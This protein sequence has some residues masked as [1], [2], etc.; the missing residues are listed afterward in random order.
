MC[1]NVQPLHEGW[2]CKTAPTLWIEPSI[3]PLFNEPLAITIAEYLPSLLVSVE[4][5]LISPMSTS[6]P[7]ATRGVLVSSLPDTSVSS[8]GVVSSRRLFST[9]T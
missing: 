7:K 1:Q 9:L 5:A 8:S 6:K 2:S 4:P 3:S